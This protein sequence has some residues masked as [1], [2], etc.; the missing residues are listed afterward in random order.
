VVLPLVAQAA[1][2]HRWYQEKFGT[3]Y[4]KHRKAIIPGIY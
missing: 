2:A 3:D 1:L 4:P